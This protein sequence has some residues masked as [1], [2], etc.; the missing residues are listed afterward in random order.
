[1]HRDELLNILRV[2][3]PTL[4]ERFGV[5]GL[6]LF[7]SFA[8]DQATDESDVDVIAAFDPPPNWKTY[9][10]AVFYLEDL[11]GRQVDLAMKEDFGWRFAPTWSGT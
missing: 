7:G 11:L 4:T 5:T 1:M 8:R 10:G 2:H 3:K 6:S 9:F